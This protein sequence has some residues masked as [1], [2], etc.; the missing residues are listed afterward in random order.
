[1]KSFGIIVGED[2]DFPED[3]IK[4]NNIIIFPF[5]VDWSELKNK[6]DFYKLMRSI[7]KGGPKTSQPA[8]AVFKRL[9]EE[10]LKKHDALFVITISSKFSG[11]YNSAIQARKS[12]NNAEKNKIHII[13]SESSSGAEAL[14]VLQILKDNNLKKVKSN[15]NKTKLFGVF[16]D[17]KWLVAG[18]RISSLKGIVVKNMIKS[19]L[20]PVL[21]I[22]SGEIV[23][24]KIQAKGRDKVEVLFAMYKD[25]ADLKVKHSV[26]ITHADCLQDAKNLAK[27]L[28]KFSQSVK[29]EYVHEISPVIGSHLGPGTLLLSWV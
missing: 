10:N 11:T 21:T 26:I 9:F 6:K 2:A 1:M 19:G 18:G 3:L 23:V 13:D 15:I 25:E 16:D 28:E 20:R 29:I 12:L 8:P 27:K 24:K 22:I 5:K 14:L 17:P 4:K 7:K